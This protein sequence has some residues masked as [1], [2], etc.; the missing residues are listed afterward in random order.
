VNLKPFVNN[1]EL[2]VDFQQELANRIQASYKKLEQVTDTVD[3]Y[4][5]QGEI[6]AL[7][8]LMKLR[9]KVNAE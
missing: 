6:Q 5:T 4:R 9:D 1:K 3:I 8:N 7:K 2:W